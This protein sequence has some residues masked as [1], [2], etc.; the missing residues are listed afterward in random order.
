MTGLLVSVRNV[1][2]ARLA[3]AAG[4]DWI[5]V[6]EPLRGSLGA[7]DQHECVQ[8]AHAVA[9]SRPLSYACGELLDW[10]CRNIEPSGTNQ[11]EP[12]AGFALAKI[13]L[14]GC[15]K[16]PWR[17][18]WREWR[19]SLPALTLPVVVIYADAAAADSPPPDELLEWAA[20]QEVTTVLVDTYAK[21]GPKLTEIWSPQKLD[22]ICRATQADN[23]RIVLA[24]KLDERDL[25]GILEL[26]P[27]LVAVR[28]AVCRSVVKDSVELPR[29]G[30]LCATKIESFR[31]KLTSFPQT[32]ETA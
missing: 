9:G 4:V 14:A 18:R 8:I 29:G 12:L 21:H 32:R 15:A 28:G 22:V 16:L 1:A 27:D 31:R 5:D 11:A 24:G 23:R 2:E 26:S 6:K 30:E 13:G 25:Q 3:L 19:D 20:D 17:R 10:S 7:A